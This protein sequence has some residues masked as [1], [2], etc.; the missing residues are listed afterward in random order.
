MMCH[1][2]FE[3]RDVPNKEVTCRSESKIDYFPC[4]MHGNE[5]NVVVCKIWLMCHAAIGS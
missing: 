1:A 3:S 5:Q 2:K 4:K